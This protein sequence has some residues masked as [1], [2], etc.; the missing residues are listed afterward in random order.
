MHNTLTLGGLPS[1]R[2]AGPSNWAAKARA[3]CIALE[4]GP[5]ARVVAEHD[6][7]V[8][9]FGRRHRRTV[10]FDGASRSQSPTNFSAF[11]KTERSAY[12]F[13]FIRAARQHLSEMELCSLP[14]PAGPLFAWKHRSADGGHHSR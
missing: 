8:A 11:R 10:D 3:S 1:S 5:I 9:R 6:G 4:D 14:L 12:R 7:Y 2:R 13:C